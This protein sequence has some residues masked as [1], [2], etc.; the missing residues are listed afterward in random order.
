MANRCLHFLNQ[1]AAT[2]VRFSLIPSRTVE[3][4]S[5]IPQ[6]HYLYLLI[7]QPVKNVFLYCC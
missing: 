3:V 6:M 5:S 2:S 4:L 1:P 7:Y